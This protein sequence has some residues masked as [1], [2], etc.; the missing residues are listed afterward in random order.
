MWWNLKTQIV[1]KLKNWKCDKIKI[2][3]NCDVTLTEIRTKLKLGQNSNCEGEKHN[4]QNVTKLNLWQNLRTQIMTNSKNG[5]KTK[6]KQL[7]QNS[8]TPIVTKL[9]MWG[10]KNSKTQN[11]TKLKL[12]Q[13][14]RTQIMTQLKHSKLWQNS[15]TQIVTV[16]EKLQISIYEE[17][18][19]LLK[20][21]LVRTFWHL[22]NRWD[23]LWAVFC[24]F[25]DVCPVW[26]ETHLVACS[27][28]QLTACS[29]HVPCTS[30]KIRSQEMNHIHVSGH[31][32][33][34]AS[35]S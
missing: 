2:K 14:S 31:C 4:N 15:E 3:S 13:N 16:L 32:L 8:K 27:C 22:D 19:K 26:E 25:R 34:P 29:C 17:E 11:V 23:V 35:C 24:N 5:D 33:L 1:M 6:K 18:K 20:G 9:K 30:S 28:Q 7:W 12:W 21:L 10:E